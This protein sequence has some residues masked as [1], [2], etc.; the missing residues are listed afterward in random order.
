M[1][2]IIACTFGLTTASLRAQEKLPP[3]S[4]HARA[5]KAREELSVAVAS[6]SETPE[7]AMARLERGTLPTALDFERELDLSLAAIDIGERLLIVQKAKEALSF[8]ASA[9]K[10]LKAYVAHTPDTA[11]RSKALALRKLAYI[12]ANF[13]GQAAQAKLDIDRA[14]QLQP[15][16]KTLLQA[17]TRLA[18]E[19]GPAFSEPPKN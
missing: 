18:N 7:G 4:A 12:R 11:A 15:D 1:A 6:G 17:R 13:L 2:C 3:T 19:R 14:V 5:V 10:L 8:F 16:D 9:E